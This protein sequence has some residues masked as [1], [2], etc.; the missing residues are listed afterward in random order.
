MVRGLQFD[1]RIFGS[2]P[3]V[4]S[5]GLLVPVLLLV[6]DCAAKP[7]AVRNA[8]VQTLS[9]H[10]ADFH[11]RHVKPVALFGRAVNLQTIGVPPRLRRL[12]RFVERSGRLRVEIVHG[13]HVSLPGKFSSTGCLIRRAE[14]R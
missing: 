8:G 6:I 1:P 11:F 14:S 7:L 4:R 5:Y 2:E 3:P 10:G 12:E 13:E 9:C